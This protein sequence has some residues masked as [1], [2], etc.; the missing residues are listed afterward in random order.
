MGR[1]LW[2]EDTTFSRA[3]TILVWDDFFNAFPPRPDP[4][5]GPSLSGWAKQIRELSSV[6]PV[7]GLTNSFSYGLR[8]LGRSLVPIFPALSLG[9]FP[10]SG[11]SAR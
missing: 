8:L 10:D 4:L 7:A 3:F 6:G 1:N 5:T 9:L 2:I 11:R